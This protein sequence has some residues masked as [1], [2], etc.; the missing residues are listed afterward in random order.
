[1]V[2]LEDQIIK[3]TVEAVK[4][5]YNV[6]FELDKVPIQRTRKD[7]RGDFTIV[8]FPFLRFSRK[9]PEET[10]N[11]IGTYLKE[12]IADIASFE[13]LKGFLNLSLAAW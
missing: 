6:D 12:K 7:L 9:G 1:M 13:S 8:V 2:R 10:A 5:L 4:A 3:T 11:E